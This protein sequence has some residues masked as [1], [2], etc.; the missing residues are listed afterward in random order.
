MAQHFDRQLI[1]SQ[2][3]LCVKESL[4]RQP[5]RE[6]MVLE[7]HLNENKQEF[8]LDVHVQLLTC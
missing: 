6:V 4:K 7:Y 3:P 2:K 1:R 8:S 5:E